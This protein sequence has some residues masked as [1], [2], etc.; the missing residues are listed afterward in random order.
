MEDSA[1]RHEGSIAARRRR[2][3][4]GLALAAV[5][6]AGVLLSGGV[7]SPDRLTVE[8]LLPPA[9]ARAL[10]TA[11]SALG[12]DAEVGLWQVRGQS[13]PP[14]PARMA[15]IESAIGALPGVAGIL[16]SENRPRLSLGDGGEPHLV[17]LRGG[18]PT[19]SRLDRFLA[20][21]ETSRIVVLRLLPGTAKLAAAETFVRGADALAVELGR[22]GAPGHE[23]HVVLSTPH[24]RVASWREASRSLWLGGPLA[25]LCAILVPALVFRSWRSVTFAALLALSTVAITLALHRL[26][27]GPLSPLELLLVPLLVALST[28]D[29]FHLFHRTGLLERRPRAEAIARRELFWPC[30]MT[31]ATTMAGL[32]ALGVQAHS[33]LLRTFG[34][35]GGVGTAVAFGLTFV[36]G[37]LVLGAPRGVHRVGYRAGVHGPVARLLG[38]VAR[39]AMRRPAP[40]ILVWLVAIASS[41]PYL[42]GVA[43][44]SRYPAIFTSDHPTASVLR[45]LGR[46]LD[47]DLA[48]VDLFVEPA[49]E[50]GATPEGLV[51]AC[52]GLHYYVRTIPETRIDFSPFLLIDELLRSDRR[53]RS[54]LGRPGGRAQLEAAMGGL[55][56]R[57]DDGDFRGW[58][59]LGDAPRA[60]LSLYFAPMTSA[61]RAEVL[62]WISRY[63]A[64]ALKPFFRLRFGGAGYV[65]Q[66]A[67]E[68]GLD[69]L[70]EGSVAGAI[71]LALLLAVALR[72]WMHL[73]IAMV[74]NLTPLVI[75]AGVMGAAEIPWSV[76]L[77]GLPVVL[78]S[79]A[80]DDTI[81]L[82]WPLRRGALRCGALRHRTQHR[83]LGGVR[84][85]AILLRAVRRTG[86]ALLA[87]TLVLAGCTA[88]SGLSRL[89]QNREAGLLLAFG[90]LVALLCDL[91]LLPALVAVARRRGPTRTLTGS[92]R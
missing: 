54:L 12:G 69:G 74:V 80:V 72:R 67:E 24:I 19:E 9:E 81:H 28:L 86:P 56:G 1:T 33:P 4:L 3:A 84:D 23:N 32:F 90:L 61:R 76:G 53:S 89:V 55:E 73:A 36:A 34:L 87:T 64:R 8:Q 82:L 21:D 20:P 38:V 68:V 29:A 39:G 6:S 16:S 47:S 2:R 18:T 45:R 63:G 30:L 75:V 13:A 85:A 60:R 50:P 48:P 11:A 57:A 77:L 78:F 5:A 26:C 35:W 79:I 27:A 43:T 46:T 44:A 22:Q 62:G 31:S 17:L 52:I 25:L 41:V 42:Q 10:R 37:P 71:L 70:V 14:S 51:G 92:R 7:V 49:G 66:R 59:R 65:Y 83:A 58:V 40:V 91:T 15:A 88:T